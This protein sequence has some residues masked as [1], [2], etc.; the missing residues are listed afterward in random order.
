MKRER[1]VKIFAAVVL[2]LGLI[3]WFGFSSVEVVAHPIAN[4]KL[5][6]EVMGTGT[7]EARIAANISCEISGRIEQV[8]VDQ[9]VQVKKGD[10]LAKLDDADRK[11]EVEIAKANIVSAEAAI[12]RVA[13]D[14]KR[15]AAV[16]AQAKREFKRNEVL[17]STKSISIATIDKSR[18]VLGVAE[19]EFARAGFAVAEGKKQFL[20]AQKTL[21]F[22]IARL[23]R[24]T[25]QAP[26]DG[27]VVRRYRNP[28]DV[29]VPGAYI[30]TVISTDELW[31][32]AWVDETEMAK[33]SPEQPARIT[34][35]SEPN[36][37]FSGVVVR[38]GRE[39]DRETG[40]FVVDVHALELPKNWAV[41][42]RAEVFIEVESKENAT[43]LPV[44]FVSWRDSE[45]GVFVQDGS[46]ARWRGLELGARGKDFIEVVKGL[47]QGEVVL[48]GK[49]SKL[50]RDAV[51]VN[52]Q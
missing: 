31:I 35:R 47:E 6:A 12:T 45:Q 11:Q 41:G 17:Y 42:Q 19:A 50:L 27:L 38:L 21:E 30:L 15:A 10:L 28:G 1:I 3:F 36:N 33:I 29:V 32:S 46:R 23:G 4:G 18:E 9:G 24:T 16:L 49:N 26:F 52:V 25:I 5:V 2:L 14:K 39:T 8:L 37:I 13:A 7:L 43:L 22:Q 48:R 51:R 44:E 40:E 34:F 20:T